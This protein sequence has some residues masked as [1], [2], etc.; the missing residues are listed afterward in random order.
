MQRLVTW[1]LIAFLALPFSGCLGEEAA[2]ASSGTYLIDSEWTVIALETKSE[3]YPDDENVSWEVTSDDV[4]QQVQDAGGIIVGISMLLEYQEDESANFGLC[5][6]LENNVPDTIYGTISKNDWTLTQ[7]EL[8]P[9]SHVVNLTWHNQSL[10]E[11]GNVTGMSE[12]EIMS[13]LDLGDEVYGTY[14]ISILVEADAFSGELCTHTDNGEQVESTISLLVIDLALSGGN[15]ITSLAVGDGEISILLFSPWF[16][17]M[18]L[19][20]ATLLIEKTCITSVLSSKKM[21][22]ANR[23]NS[24]KELTKKRPKVTEKLWLKVTRPEFS[25]YVHFMWHKAFL[26]DS[27]QSRL[28]P[29]SLSRALQ[30]VS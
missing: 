26:G 11:V 14:N 8:N 24:G 22:R 25:P 17:G 9:G 16:I 27:S 3:Y 2:N 29:I 23:P 10:L 6:G 30:L 15:G 21:I 5:T 12:D 13:Q 4:I 28:S 7:N 18:F 20:V 19:L 1:I